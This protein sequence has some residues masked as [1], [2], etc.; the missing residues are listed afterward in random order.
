MLE[1]ALLAYL[2]VKW[3]VVKC[4]NTSTAANL[5]GPFTQA[6]KLVYFDQEYS[7]TRWISTRPTAWSLKQLSACMSGFP[8]INSVR[9]QSIL[10]PPFLPSKWQHIRFFHF[11]FMC[12]QV[13]KV[14]SCHWAVKA[15]NMDKERQQHNWLYWRRI[16]GL[17]VLNCTVIRDLYLSCKH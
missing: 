2:N 13:H 6:Q 10:Q 9:L 1:C 14:Y 17:L 11:R 7:Y 16:L 12:K 5:R 3:T 4:K 8:A 15:L